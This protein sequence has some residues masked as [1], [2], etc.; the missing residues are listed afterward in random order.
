MAESRTVM[1]PVSQM[2][3][4]GRWYLGSTCL[5]HQPLAL[6]GDVLLGPFTL[7][8]HLKSR[9]GMTSAFAPQ[10]SV[11][12]TDGG[13]DLENGKPPSRANANVCRVVEAW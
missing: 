7:A 9:E 4:M 12:R 11:R 5:H 6:W 1:M 13:T 3:L 8:I 10:H 2:E